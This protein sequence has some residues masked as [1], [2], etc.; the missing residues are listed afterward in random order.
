MRY[1]DKSRTVG[2][3][4]FLFF[5]TVVLSNHINTHS[6]LW[7]QVQV[8]SA[9]VPPPTIFYHAHIAKTA[10]SSF[11]RIVARRYYGV[12]GHKGYTFSQKYLDEIHGTTDPDYPGYGLDRVHPE[13]ME[14]WGFHNCALISH[15]IGWKMLANATIWYKF[16]QGVNIS[17][18]RIPQTKLLIPCRDPVDHLFSQCNFNGQNFT[19]LTISLGKCDA[20]IAKC[21]VGWE[22]YDHGIIPYFDKIVLYEYDDFDTVLQHLD[23]SL[24]KRIFALDD[25]KHGFYRTNDER[26]NSSELFTP[27]CPELEL[28]DALLQAW[29]YY[30]LCNAFL[31]ASSWQEFDAPT[32]LSNINDWVL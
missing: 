5:A 10:G 11:N 3:V 8:V 15:E 30:R 29:S 6:H 4:S 25:S 7:R 16:G 2:I 20:V 27:Q 28:R 17:S 24:P 1:R 31:G 32:L 21:S 9:L 18:I 14:E 22:R 23:V 13:R 19:Y 26:S 12:C